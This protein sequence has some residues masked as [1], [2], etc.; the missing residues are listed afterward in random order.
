MHC[1]HGNRVIEARGSHAEQPADGRHGQ[2]RVS[3]LGGGA[4]RIAL[5]VIVLCVDNTD[6]LFSSSECLVERFVRWRYE[7]DVLDWVK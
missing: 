1:K 3:N 6:Q 5:T 7:D 2:P 4:Y